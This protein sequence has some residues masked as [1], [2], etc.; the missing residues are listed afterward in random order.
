MT[1]FA[2]RTYPG[3]ITGLGA[4]YEMES[5]G[6]PCAMNKN[7]QRATFPVARAVS[8]DNRHAGCAASN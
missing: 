3:M 4:G 2:F 1:S 6:D 8:S 5:L 7:R